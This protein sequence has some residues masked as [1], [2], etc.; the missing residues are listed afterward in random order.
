MAAGVSSGLV[1]WWWPSAV[2]SPKYVAPPQPPGASAGSIMEGNSAS[3]PYR[4]ITFVFVEVF[5]NG[6]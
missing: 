1:L 6:R 4:D 2:T 5:Y 3:L